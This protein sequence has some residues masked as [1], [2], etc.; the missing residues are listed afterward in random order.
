MILLLEKII[1]SIVLYIMGGN[2]TFRIT[3]YNCTETRK[4]FYRDLDKMR[5]A[6]AMEIGKKKERPHL[7]IFITF[8]RTYGFKSLKT[9]LGPETHFEASLCSDWNYELKDMKYELQDFRKQGSRSDRDATIEILTSG[10]GM[11]D[12]CTKHF[13]Y[14]LYRTAEKWLTYM[15]APRE[16]QDIDIRWYHGSSGSGKTRSVYKEF[17]T[18]VFCPITYKWWDGYDGQEVILIDDFRKDYCK[19][20]ELLK[21]LDEYPYRVEFKGGSRQMK[22]KTLVLTCPFHWKDTYS[23]R[24]D[25]FQLERRITTTKLFGT[26]VGVGNTNY[27]DP[28]ELLDD[29]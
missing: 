13:N 12:V 27:P 17:G 6:L 1:F 29:D 8:K 16:I 25:L 22:A 23:T 11:R 26:E 2:K 21:L 7:Q 14:Q 5:M 4:Q 15:E 24:E 18:E 3:D 19:Y 9:I 10:G 28:C 20:H